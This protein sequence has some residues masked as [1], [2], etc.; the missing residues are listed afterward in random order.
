MGKVSTP[1]DYSTSIRHTGECAFQRAIILNGTSSVNGDEIEWMDIELPV[2]E[3]INPRGKCI[4]L[5]GKDSE[6]NYVLCE[7]KFRKKI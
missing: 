2:D 6:G 7:L 1:G 3:R 5:I 4:D